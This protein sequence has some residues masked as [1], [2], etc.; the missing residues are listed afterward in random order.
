VRV[1]RWLRGYGGEAV[2]YACG[3]FRENCV[4]EVYWSGDVVA[5]SLE[6]IN[7]GCG[8]EY[9]FTVSVL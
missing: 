6:F 4:E 5:Y 9:D 3:W 7:V 8:F 2:V 1:E